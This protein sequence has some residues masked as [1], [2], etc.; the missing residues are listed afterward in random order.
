M[1]TSPA[2]DRS[3]WIISP[4][5]DL[6]FFANLWWMGFVFL[7]S[8]GFGTSDDGL[9]VFWQVYFVT[10]PHRWLTLLLVATD[11]DRRQGRS[12]RFIL[13]A[14]ASA[15][16]VVSFWGAFQS[17]H[18]LLL[19]DFLWNAWHFGSQHHG[20]LRMYSRKGGGGRPRLESNIIRFFVLY[21]ALRAASRLNGWLDVYPVLIQVT[22]WTDTIAL[23][24]PS[25]LVVLE[26]VDS[27]VRRLGKIVYLC[28]VYAIYASFLLAVRM[29]AF[30]WILPLA[31]ATAAFHAIEYMAF[32]TYYAQRRKDMG[33]QSLFQTMT[34]NW[35]RVLA[36][37]VLLTGLISSYAAVVNDRFAELFIGLNIW[38]AYLH[39]AYDGMIWKMRRSETAKTLGVELRPV[40]PTA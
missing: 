32:V 7:P 36:F 9:L 3:R 16:V 4:L 23:L 22:F 10:T 18:C 5:F 20:I 38:A 39:Y 34:R 40:Q 26:L 33:S 13:I 30:A 17:F 37:Y 6:A 35:V 28:S 2:N 31:V 24:L 21:V 12:W 27:P 11:P 15:I 1:S 19:A 8:Y 29:S 25:I 14:V